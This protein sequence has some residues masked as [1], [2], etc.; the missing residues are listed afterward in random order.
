MAEVGDGI[1][2][3][4]DVEDFGQVFNQFL[5]YKHMNMNFLFVEGLQEVDL[6]CKATKWRSIN[7]F[8][9]TPRE[10]LRPSLFVKLKP[11]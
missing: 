8:N 4:A 1:D 7:P 11:N 2:L 3:Y 6:Y 9:F 10:R 5:Y